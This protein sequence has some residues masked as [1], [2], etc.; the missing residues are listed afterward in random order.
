MSLR[1]AEIKYVLNGDVADRSGLFH[2]GYFSLLHCFEELLFRR[3]DLGEAPCVESTTTFRNVMDDNGSPSEIQAFT[4]SITQVC[5]ILNV[6]VKEQSLHSE[7]DGNT[8]R[9]AFKLEDHENTIVV[10]LK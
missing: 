9:V 4:E 5:S 3:G 6:R 10:V 2:V 8:F 1:P 7:M